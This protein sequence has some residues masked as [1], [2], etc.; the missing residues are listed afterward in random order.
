M[1][2]T[3]GQLLVEEALSK[4]TIEAYANWKDAPEKLLTD[5]EKG[6]EYNRWVIV[7]LHHMYNEKRTGILEII[8]KP[9]AL[10]P[11]TKNLAKSLLKILEEEEKGI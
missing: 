6:L 8:S 10:T 1:D 9:E 5:L 4:T 7:I 2:K 3:P 11:V